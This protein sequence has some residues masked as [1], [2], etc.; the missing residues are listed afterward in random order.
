MEHCNQLGSSTKFSQSLGP[1]SLILIYTQSF[2]PSVLSVYLIRIFLPIVEEKKKEN[3][4]TY[5]ARLK[6]KEENEILMEQREEAERVYMNKLW[7]ERERLA[8][9]EFRMQKEREARE[10]EKKIETEVR[11]KRQLK[12]IH[13]IICVCQS[14]N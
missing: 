12:T 5:Q 10:R 11:L 9:E 7:E 2:Y 8:Q 3:S 1:S 14:F 13:I 4:P 6:E